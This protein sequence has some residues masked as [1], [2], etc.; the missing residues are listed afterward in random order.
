MGVKS[1]DIVAGANLVAYQSDRRVNLEER[2]MTRACYTLG[3]EDLDLCYLRSCGVRAA[4]RQ[5]HRAC[6][7]ID[8]NLS[9]TTHDI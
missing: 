1:E 7:P 6:D 4:V 9:P 8:A 2:L 5:S 3:V